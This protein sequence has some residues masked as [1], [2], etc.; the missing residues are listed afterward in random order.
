MPTKEIA[1]ESM[2]RHYP[3]M[4]KTNFSLLT[5][6]LL[7]SSGVM[8]RVIEPI[9]YLCDAGEASAVEA[10][11]GV[12]SWQCS[13]SNGG[14]S[15]ECLAPGLKQTD[16]IGTSTFTTPSENGCAIQRVNQVLPINNGP[17]AGVTMPY[18][19]IDFEMTGCQASV[20]TVKMTYS[21]I[22]EGMVFWKYIRGNWLELTHANSG[23][24]VEGNIVTF[25]IEDNG[26]YDADPAI[27]SIADPSGPGYVVFPAAPGIPSAL[28]AVAGDSLAT[29]NWQ[30]PENG[31]AA[32]R[33]TVTSAPE[34]QTCTV[35]APLTTCAVSG[36]TNNQSYTFTVVAEN[37]GGTGG[38]SAVSNVVKLNTAVNATSCGEAYGLASLLPPETDLCPLGAKSSFLTTQKGQHSWACT[39]IDT[40][41]SSR[42]VAPGAS[43]KGSKL[44]TTFSLLSGAGCIIESAKLKKAPAGLPLGVKL[45]YGVVSFALNNC[46]ADSATLSQ[47]FSTSI[48]KM[49]LWKWLHQTWITLPDT[50]MTGNTV[51]FSLQDNGPYDSNPIQ[52]EIVDPVGIGTSNKKATQSVLQLSVN[53]T[54]VTSG[55]AVQL[56]TT[57]G[58]GK[59]KVHYAV[60]ASNY[61]HCVINRGNLKATISGDKVGTCTAWAIKS[62]DKTYNATV[63]NPVTIS[64]QAGKPPSSITQK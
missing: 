38:V 20:A 17:G 13:G 49:V 56:I 32:V 26:P 11:Q 40:G 60:Q 6:A 64:V 3:H 53:N 16:S 7:T 61:A 50:L 1:E 12:Y 5:L 55:Q 43:L 39:A 24:I 46:Q 59:G 54:E 30:A 33:Y 14:R 57:G 19:V 9:S 35:L 63:S 15:A 47:S 10:D 42:C 45:P 34:N 23:L 22:V 36:L 2:K 27:G 44:S 41:I 51:T 4:T 25:T 58:S 52:G 31:G 62:A 29:L 37:A 8:A 18:N 21:N 28:K 48:N